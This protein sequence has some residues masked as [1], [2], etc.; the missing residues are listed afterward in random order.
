MWKKKDALTL[1]ESYFR[2]DEKYLFVEILPWYYC[3]SLPFLSV[4]LCYAISLLF[5]VYLWDEIPA[6]GIAVY[7]IF[8]ACIVYYAVTRSVYPNYMVVSQ[9]AIYRFIK[10]SIQQFDE[11]PL[12]KIEAIRI[13]PF[14]FSKKHAIM[15]VQCT[16]EYVRSRPESK[17]Q[18]EIRHAQEKPEKVDPRFLASR[19]PTKLRVVIRKPQEYFNVFYELRNVMGYRYMLSAERVVKCSQKQNLRRQK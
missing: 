11:I 3:F 12:C 9:Q 10:K 7:L 19:K 16:K 2:K 15:T 14:A 8:G 4:V 17:R 6:F 13:R 5:G 1:A 18:Y